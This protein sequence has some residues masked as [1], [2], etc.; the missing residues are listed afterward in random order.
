MS[1]TPKLRIGQ[2]FDV[3]CFAKNR[4]LILGGLEIDHSQGLAGH[5]DA[6]VLL[7]AITDA[8]LGALCWGDIGQWFPDTDSQYEG[9][10]SGE[11]LS[12]VWQKVQEEGWGLVNC[13]CVLMAQEPKLQDYKKKMQANIAGLFSVA[14]DCISVKAT[15]TEKLGFVGRGEGI[16]ATAIV[17][18]S[19]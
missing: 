7:H 17:L 16:A 13:D 12:Q 6:D 4:K 9:A 10:D 8:V 15:T 2:G 11:L 18:L 5:S 3:H 1:E 19:T 14:D